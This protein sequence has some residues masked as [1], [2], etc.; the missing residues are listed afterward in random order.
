MS[1]PPEHGMST[2]AYS[3]HGGLVCPVASKHLKLANAAVNPR[4]VLRLSAE[5]RR[6]S[7]GS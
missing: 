7:E 1:T 2:E 3:G 4:I 5:V 6:P